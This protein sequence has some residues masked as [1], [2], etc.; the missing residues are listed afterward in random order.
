M[1]LDFLKKKK[2]SEEHLPMP[3]PPIPKPKNFVGDIEEIRPKKSGKEILE[4]DLSIPEISMD[5][6]IPEEPETFEQPNSAKMTFREHKPVY[7]D[8]PNDFQE[9]AQRKD[10]KKGPLFISVNDYEKIELDINSM[11]NLLDDAE[12]NIQEMNDVVSSENDFLDKWRAYLEGI[13]KKLSF[14]DKI[15]ENSG[16]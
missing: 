11:K 2:N 1:G 15:I 10:I 9:E 4:Q 14:V 13:E 7:F 12:N 6:S 16:E 8:E 3:P 5:S